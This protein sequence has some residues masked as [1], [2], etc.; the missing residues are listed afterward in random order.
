MRTKPVSLRLGFAGDEFG[1]AIDLG[2]PTERDSAFSLDPVIKRECVW[3][4]P[5]LRPATLLADRGAAGVRDPG[6]DRRLGEH[7][8]PDQADGQHAQRVRRPRRR[9][10]NC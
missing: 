4:G 7:G 10:R 2:L 1:Y 3:R 8:R 5:L 9:A 6:R